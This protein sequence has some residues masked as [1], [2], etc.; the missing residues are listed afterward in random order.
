M[1]VLQPERGRPTPKRTFNRWVQN[2]VLE[3]YALRYAPKSFR[4]WSEWTVMNSALGGIAYMADFAIGGS[5]VLAY[6][7]ANAVTSILVVA[8]IIFLT[9]IP[10]AYYSA[11]YNIDMDLLT[12]GA[13]FGYYGSTLTS[14]VYASFTFIYFSLEGS[15]MAQALEEF[16]HIPLPIGYLICSL[17]IIPLVMFGMTA[18]SK[19]Q[20]VTQPIWL[21]LMLGPFIAIALRD[22][23]AFS[24]WTHFGGAS[25]SG[26]HFNAIEFGLAAGVT[27][28]LI[29]QIGEQVDYLRFMPNLTPQNRSKWWWAVMLAGPGWV[30]LG[31][32]KQLGGSLLASWIAPT[33][34]TKA[35]DEPINMY[36]QAFYTVLGSSYAALALATFFVLLSQI[37]I[38]VTNA[39]SGSLS[40]SNFF[41]RI[42]HTHP[43]RV[44][45]LFLNVGIALGLMEAGVFGFLNTV[46]GFYSNLAVAWIGAVV[47]DLVIN[48]G[49][50]KLSPS[51]I[52]FKRGHL[53]NFN[54][55]GF[56]SMIIAA[57]I[58]IAAFFGAFGPVLQAYSPFL[59]LVLAFVLAP[60]IAIVT[61][62]KYYIARENTFEKSD[63]HH[64]GHRHSE[65]PAEFTCA[66]CGFEYEKMDMLYCPFHKAPICSLCCSLE[67][68]CHDLCKAGHVH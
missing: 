65:L 2:P 3:D 62:G 32:I 54:P 68:K 10:I 28:S 55:V 22:P 37:K 60:V 53:Y 20:V 59:S 21:V 61:R 5:V 24:Q 66:S 33:M 1:S 31:A 15:V 17:V 35:A 56:G 11:K 39:Y 12:R 50:L 7:F 13:G 36:T 26:S 47:S 18:L 45:W 40:W 19:L 29:A 58:S 14:L 43:G 64:D 67:S 63:R 38:N 6:G 42:F 49:L 23:Q 48:K 57:G 34:G 46:L 30:I 25:A 8:A 4:R 44:V 27:L 51:Y 16:F 41:S 52:E 9:G